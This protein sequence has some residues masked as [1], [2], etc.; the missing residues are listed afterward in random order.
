LKGVGVGDGFT[1]PYF[2]FTQLGE[3][4]YNL[5]LVDYQERTTIEHLILNA[6]YQERTRNMRDMHMS[7]DLAF[8][9]LNT[10]TGG[11]N[12]YDITKYQ[13]YPTQLL[14]S[15]LGSPDNKKRFALNPDIKY[16]AQA[17]N[18]YE[19][20]YDDFM[21]QYVRLVEE[22]LEAK[23]PVMIYNGQNDLIV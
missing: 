16:G 23:V 2:I 20:L 5:G 12:V 17:G 6:T 13:D 1:H 7:F 15:F 10:M 14:D 19:G 9:L 3:F 22:L 18:V 4:A 11:I 8:D 21:R